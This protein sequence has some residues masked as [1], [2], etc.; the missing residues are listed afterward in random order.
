MIM[1]MDYMASI[2]TKSQACRSACTLGTIK[3]IALLITPATHKR[4]S[5]VAN[6]WE[7]CIELFSMQ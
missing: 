7:I 6:D 2:Y 5:M 1:V 4:M 3:L